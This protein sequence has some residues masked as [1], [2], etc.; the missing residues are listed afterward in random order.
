M[1]TTTRS[2]VFPTSK[3]AFQ[4]HVAKLTPPKG[5]SKETK[6][7]PRHFGPMMVCTLTSGDGDIKIRFDQSGSGH[8]EYRA[9]EK[10]M[11]FD[12]R[13]VE[14]SFYHLPLYEGMKVNPINAIVLEQIARINAARAFDQVAIDVPTIPFRVSPDRA[15]QLKQQVKRHGHVTF[16]PSG[17]GTGYTVSKKHGGHGCTRAKPELEKFLGHSPLFVTMFDAD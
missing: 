10:W 8:T 2:Q 17:F 11:T 16:V 9:G 14:D 3:T 6:E 13:G 12:R 4:K 15:D 7:E 1:A 5:W